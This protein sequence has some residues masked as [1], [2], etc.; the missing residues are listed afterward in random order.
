MKGL[1]TNIFNFTTVKNGVHCGDLLV[2]QP[3][4]SESWFSRGVISL[5]DY[6]PKSGATGVVLNNRMN[7]TLDQVLDGVSEEREVA[8]YCGGPL[9][10]DRLFFVHTL[11]HDIIPGGREYAPGLYIGG[12]FDKAVEYINEGYPTEGAI[13]FFIGYSGWERKQLEKEIEENTWATFTAAQPLQYLLKGEGNAYWNK[14]V[15]DL[16]TP[17]R[18]WLM[19][20]EDAHSN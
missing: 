8:V 6:D 19:I 7:Y 17:Y 13:R 10:Q 4:L 18:S 16:G 12:D 11:G 2:A 1:D 14:V 20:P 9:S 5:I 3:F 15:R